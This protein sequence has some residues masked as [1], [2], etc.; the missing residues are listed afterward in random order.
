PAGEAGGAQAARDGAAVA[1]GPP[2]DEGAR[3]GAPAAQELAAAPREQGADGRT[4]PP[5]AAE[6]GAAE[7]G[8]APQRPRA[9]PL[10]RRMAR[11]R[12]VDLGTLRGSGPGGRIVKADVLSA[13]AAQ[14]GGGDERLAAAG[15]GVVAPSG[16]APG[17]EAQPPSSLPDPMRAKG[18]TSSVQLNRTQQTI[19][20]R[21][22]ES[23]A[24]IPD[25]TLQ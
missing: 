10:A 22:A 7:G 23:K 4:G 6:A 8:A 17:A 13:P 9:S 5:A 20:R 19:A 14:L 21:M 16:A 25:F 1:G 24:T 2:S 12:G 11:E 18:E 15:A 3:P